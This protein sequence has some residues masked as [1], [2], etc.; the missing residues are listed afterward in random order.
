MNAG[1]TEA[2]ATIAGPGFTLT[3]APMTA[4]GAPM[5][6]AEAIAATAAASAAIDKSRLR[7]APFLFGGSGGTVGC[8]KI[9]RLRGVRAA[10]GGGNRVPERD[11]N[12]PRASWKD[13]AGPPR[14]TPPTQCGRTARSL[15]A[16]PGSMILS[17]LPST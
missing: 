12:S 16:T 5:I 11:A 7:H 14:E 3:A 13:Q 15:R 9:P 1:G 17:M 10:R 4:L 6:T 8:K 2:A